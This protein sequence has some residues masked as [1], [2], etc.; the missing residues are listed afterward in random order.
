MGHWY[1]EADSCLTVFTSVFMSTLKFGGASVVVWE[2]IVALKKIK[3]G[4]VAGIDST[5]VEVLKNGGIS[6]IYWLL[7]IF[8]RC[9]EADVVPEDWEAAFIVLIYKDM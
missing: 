8:S 6:I 3:G 2:I 4:K 5:V 9:M 7:R 1:K